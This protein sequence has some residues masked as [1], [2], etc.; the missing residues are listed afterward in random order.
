MP[1]LN[2]PK[3]DIAV[4]FGRM[5]GTANYKKHGKEGMR[6]AANSRWKNKKHDR[7]T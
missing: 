6:K 5:G 3:N 7:T 4:K 1:K 2:K